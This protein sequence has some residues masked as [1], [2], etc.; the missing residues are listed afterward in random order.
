MKSDGVFE[1]ALLPGALA[2]SVA[3]WYGSVTVPKGGTNDRGVKELSVL[4]IYGLPDSSKIDAPQTV[5]GRNIYD[6]LLKD[7]RPFAD[8]VSGRQV[9]EAEASRRVTRHVLPALTG[10]DTNQG[11][12]DWPGGRPCPAA[13]AGRGHF[14]RTAQ[15]GK[16]A[17]S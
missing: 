16:D 4:M 11:Q 6:N 7:L 1:S 9:G 12:V 3:C 10:Q 15:T 5:S 13:M 8:N 14:R 2:A 17:T